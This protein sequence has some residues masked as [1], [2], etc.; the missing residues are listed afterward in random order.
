MFRPPVIK[1]KTSFIEFSE[2]ASPLLSNS[3]TFSV[4]KP[5]TMFSP[6]T[7]PSGLNEEALINN[8]F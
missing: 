7:L 2:D 3:V 1:H 5:K 6:S 8:D 4:S